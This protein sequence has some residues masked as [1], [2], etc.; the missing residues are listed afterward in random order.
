MEQQPD[1]G[2]PVQDRQEVEEPPTQGWGECCRTG[3][4]LGRSESGWSAMKRKR[5][6]DDSLERKRGV[7]T[8]VGAGIR[9]LFSTRL[10]KQP[11]TCSSGLG[12]TRQDG[13]AEAAGGG[14]SAIVVV[15]E[16]AGRCC[17]ARVT[18]N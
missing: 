8:L 1:Q 15:I 6:V 10:G 7:S 4:E 9:S 12:P 18:F 16:E 13:V 2:G 14:T 3:S 5:D 11:E 17:E